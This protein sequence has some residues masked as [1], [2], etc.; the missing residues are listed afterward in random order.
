MDLHWVPSVVLKAHKLTSCKTRGQ[1][2]KRAGLGLT[3]SL[4]QFSSS[5]VPRSSRLRVCLL[6]VTMK[7]ATGADASPALNRLISPGMSSFLNRRRPPKRDDEGRIVKWEK[8]KKQR[9][10]VSHVNVF[11]YF[12][13]VHHSNLIFI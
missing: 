5:S 1:F 11:Q 2:L 6:Y 3:W 12:K 4:T 9:R 13:L 10:T 7:P 8:K